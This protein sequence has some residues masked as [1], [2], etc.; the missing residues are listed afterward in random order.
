MRLQRELR[1]TAHSLFDL[2]SLPFALDG[3][4]IF[5]LLKQLDG[6]GVN[7]RGGGTV[8]GSAMAMAVRDNVGNAS[9]H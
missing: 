3:L 9:M 7:V 6:L 1:R 8:A 5:A 4:G 2:D